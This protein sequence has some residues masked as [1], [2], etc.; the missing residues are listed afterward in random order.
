MMTMT[1]MTMRMMTTTDNR[2]MKAD[3]DQDTLIPVLICVNKM[4]R[5]IYAYQHD[6][7]MIQL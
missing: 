6:C 1:V 2:M 5:V 3:R 7:D 4:S